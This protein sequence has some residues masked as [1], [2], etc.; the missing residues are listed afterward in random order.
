MSNGFSLP[1]PPPPASD[2]YKTRPNRLTIARRV[3]AVASSPNFGGQFINLVVR[4]GEDEEC[5]E[6]KL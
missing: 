2:L 5:L 1:V 6:F 4:H 3:T